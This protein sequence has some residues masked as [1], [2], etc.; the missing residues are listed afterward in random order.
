MF[1][2]ASIFFNLGWEF[3]PNE[4]IVDKSALSHSKS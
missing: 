2:Q 3:Q 4:M 1:M